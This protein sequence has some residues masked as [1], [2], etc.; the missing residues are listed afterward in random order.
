MS[1]FG[2]TLCFVLSRPPA[3]G[4][5]SYY[6]FI[7]NL[8]VCDLEND[9]SGSYKTLTFA[10]A[11]LGLTYVFA[12]TSMV[13]SYWKIFQITRSHVR[14][15]NIQRSFIRSS[16][17]SMPWGKTGRVDDTTVSSSQTLDETQEKSVGKKRWWNKTPRHNRG[18]FSRAS[19][20]QTAKS[21]LIVIGVYFLC[22]TP[23][24]FTL[25][26][27]II[28]STKINPTAALVCLWIGYS[29]S[30]LNPLIYTWKYKQFRH[31]LVSISKKKYTNEFSA[32]C[33]WEGRC[34]R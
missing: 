6:C 25:A 2:C 7:P 3:F 22:W 29:N 9:W 1:L 16:E 31:A 32:S 33:S 15:I 17:T 5:S 10:I 20:I 30:C 11:V 14:R 21:F 19:D 13:V 28:L 34:L 18:N 24:C 23:F 12:L 26:L 27:D 8:D 4:V